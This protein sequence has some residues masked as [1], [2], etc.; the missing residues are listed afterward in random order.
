MDTFKIMVAAGPLWN[1]DDA[2]KKGPFI[3]AAHGGRFTGVWRTVIEGK[4]SVVECEIV[5]PTANNVKF[6]LDVPAGPIWNNEDAKWKCEA[7]CAS[8][9]G[10]WTGKWHTIVEGAMSVCE[11][12]FNW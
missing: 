1:N 8:Y 10:K 9:N 11:C 2:Q 7:I 12:E 5:Y 4:M 3:C 6:K